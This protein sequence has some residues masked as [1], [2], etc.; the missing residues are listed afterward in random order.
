[1]LFSTLFFTQEVFVPSRT[2]IQ[3]GTLKG[4]IDLVLLNS[5]GLDYLSN[6]EILLKSIEI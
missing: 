3:D 4:H 5:A 1:M 6:L 2:Q